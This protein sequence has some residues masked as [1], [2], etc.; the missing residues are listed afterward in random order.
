MSEEKHHHHLFHHKKEDENPN[1]SSE[2]VYAETTATFVD[3]D[4]EV[5]QSA[6]VYGAGNV[7]SD[8]YEKALK[9]EKHH[10]RMEHLGELG[11]VAAGAYALVL[12]LPFHS[13]LN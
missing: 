4:G 11:A 10:K 2:V 6:D 5:T 1:A 7:K 9:E 8:E 12:S 3:G 13:Y